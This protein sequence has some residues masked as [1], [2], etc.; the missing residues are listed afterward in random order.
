MAFK[1][2]NDKFMPVPV[3]NI[4]LAYSQYSE[5]DF[6]KVAEEFER[7]A[8]G[9]I[10]SSVNLTKTLELTNGQDLVTG[11]CKSYVT[12]KLHEMI[13]HPNYIDLA[14]DLMV[15]FRDN[16]KRIREAQ[17]SEG[18]STSDKPK[19]RKLYIFRGKDG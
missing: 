13:A 12:A 3:K 19:I 8:I 14:A 1:H 9:V 7:E 11:L 5:E 17:L 15:N 10:D 16:L 6:D 18:E 2:L 4:L